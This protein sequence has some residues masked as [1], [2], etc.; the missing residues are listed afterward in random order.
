MKVKIQ[1]FYKI[2]RTRPKFFVFGLSETEIIEKNKKFDLYFLRI[3]D[4]KY[5]H[6]KFS[7]AK[8]YFSLVTLN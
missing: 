1:T 4:F 5:N 6:S 7:Y 3:S 8:I 2:I